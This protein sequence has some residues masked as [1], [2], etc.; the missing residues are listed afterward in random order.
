MKPLI[1]AIFISLIP[2]SSL[3]IVN[4]ALRSTTK[5][6]SSMFRGASRINSGLKLRGE[7][8]WA[9]HEG[10]DVIHCRK[11]HVKYLNQYDGLVFSMYRFITTTLNS[12][13]NYYIANIIILVVVIP[14]FMFFMLLK[15]LKLTLE[16]RKIKNR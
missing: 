11:Y 9:C 1:I 6:N 2:I 14:A 5:T 16:I 3:F 15:T 12:F 8:T 13:G 10:F 4:E 7:C